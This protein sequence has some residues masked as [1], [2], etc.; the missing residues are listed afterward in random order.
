MTDAGQNQSIATVC[1][2]AAE[3]YL[4]T[5]AFDHRRRVVAHEFACQRVKR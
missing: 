3:L 2:P 5:S 1:F 4:F